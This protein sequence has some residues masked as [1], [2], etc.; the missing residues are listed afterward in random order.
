[1]ATVLDIATTA[2]RKIGVVASGEALQADQAADALAELNRIV[3]AWNI[4]RQMTDVERRESFPLVVGQQSYTMGSGGNFN[5]TR[6]ARIDRAELYVSSQALSMPVDIIDD[7]A[8]SLIQLKATQS[9]YPRRL[10][11]QGGSGATI[12]LWLW[13][14]PSEI[15]T[16]VLY[17][18]GPFAGFTATSDSFSLPDGYEDAAIYALV[19]RLCPEYGRPLTDELRREAIEARARLKVLNTG[20]ASKLRSDPGILGRSRFW[21]YRTGDYR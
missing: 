19:E 17:S 20:R 2:L 18:W 11:N 5:T 12:T 16:L 10:W 4:Q 13:P 1:M 14:V 15:N 21:D 7:Q 3:K 9:Q 6:P 8:F